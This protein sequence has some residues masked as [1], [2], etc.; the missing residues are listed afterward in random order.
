MIG[1]D[2]SIKIPLLHKGETPT[3]DEFTAL[4]QHYEQVGILLNQ[5][6]CGKYLSLGK[7]IVKISPQVANWIGSPVL[8]EGTK[9]ASQW[10]DSVENLVQTRD[11][12]GL[13]LRG[14]TRAIHAF[15][16]KVANGIERAARPIITRCP[17]AL[18]NELDAL[19]HIVSY[20]VSNYGTNELYNLVSGKRKRED[21][22]F[23]EGQEGEKE[24]NEVKEDSFGPDLK[25]AR[26]GD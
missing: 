19:T 18:A 23:Q 24:P 13:A 21:E 22:L 12:S 14:E 26:I 11:F 4:Y 15:A 25:K 9:I 6:R 1:I 10:V 17:Q 7:T 20:K 16:S 5:L 2:V 8:V 3:S